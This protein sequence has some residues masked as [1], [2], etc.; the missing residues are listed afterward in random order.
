M[1]EG[2]GLSAE[3]VDSLLQNVEARAPVDLPLKGLDGSLLQAAAQ[4]FVRCIYVVL[5][6][7]PDQ[8]TS[9]LQVA[10][11][12][13]LPKDRLIVLSVS[14]AGFVQLAAAQ[15]SDDVRA[16]AELFTDSRSQES[17]REIIA[18]KVTTVDDARRAIKSGI[19][20]YPL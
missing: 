3:T 16:V 14:H 5:Q 20:K 12:Y 10:K 1:K 8:P 13:G 7:S 15:D 2:D 4:K 19:G 6:Y 9:L 11:R 18:R 17:A